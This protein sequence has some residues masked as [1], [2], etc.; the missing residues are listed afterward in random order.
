MHPTAKHHP[1]SSDRDSLSS[2]GVT[3]TMLHTAHRA[4]NRVSVRGWNVVAI[5]PTEVNQELAT[6]PLL[7]TGRMLDAEAMRLYIGPY[8]GLTAAFVREASSRGEGCMRFSDDD[9]LRAHEWYA[10]RP[11][12][13]TETDDNRSL[14][15]DPTHV[16]MQNGSTLPRHRGE[17][18]HALGMVAALQQ[19]AKLEG[20]VSY[21]DATN[22]ASLKSCVRMGHATVG[23]VAFF[24]LGKSHLRHRTPGCAR[25]GVVITA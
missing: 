22:F 17:R 21:V 25:Y 11:V 14:S 1:L 18:L 23:R 12:W 2:N 9:T 19:F 13:P 6:H 10:T 5:T 24:R 16:H 8:I 3:T 15:V 20:L 4:A 7:A